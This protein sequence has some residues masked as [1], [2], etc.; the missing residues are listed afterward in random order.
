MSK[1]IIITAVTMVLLLTLSANAHAELPEG[2]ATFFTGLNSAWDE[3]LDT[4]LYPILFAV[5]GGMIILSLVK[6]G[7]KRAAS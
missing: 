1:N 5:T 7:A 6:K 4:Y 3:L 2:V